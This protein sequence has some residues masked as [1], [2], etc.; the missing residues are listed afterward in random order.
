M[1]KG[2]HDQAKETK[3][4]LLRLT[5]M[6]QQ[7]R[8]RVRERHKKIYSADLVE[9]FFAYPIITPVSLGKRLGVNYRTAS[10]YLAELAK[11][12]VLEESYAGKYHLFIN[13]P[14]LALLKR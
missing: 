6:L 7:T 2:V 14:L 4:L 1:L 12:K 9:S 11:G 10:R 8:E 3:E 5:D 13:K